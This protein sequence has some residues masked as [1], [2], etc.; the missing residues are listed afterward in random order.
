[1]EDPAHDGV[2][3]PATPGTGRYKLETLPKEDLI[4]FA[5]KQMMLIQKAKSRCTELEKEIEELRSKSGG[6]DN[7]IKA[8]TERLDA[9][10]LKKQRLSNSV[11]L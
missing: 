4:K 6:T 1:M 11:F 9:I 5:K 7:I 2:A 10:L 3:S 8:L